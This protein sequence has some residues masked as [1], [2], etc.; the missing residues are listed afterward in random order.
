MNK[1]AN[2]NKQITEEKKEKKRFASKITNKGVIQSA[3]FT[4]IKYII[5]KQLSMKNK[6]SIIL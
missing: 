4:G 3:P 1:K 6:V 2:E 5:T